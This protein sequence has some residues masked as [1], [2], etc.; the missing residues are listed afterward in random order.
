MQNKNRLINEFL[1]DLEGL[2][3]IDIVKEIKQRFLESNYTLI[4]TNHLYA[5]K[6][7]HSNLK[8]NL[9]SLSEI[10]HDMEC[11]FY[12]DE[13]FENCVLKATKN[14]KNVE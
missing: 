14:L 11:D 13:M 1:T 6:M 4:N 9:E 5:L 10:K 2:N 12:T 7:L 3:A 8:N